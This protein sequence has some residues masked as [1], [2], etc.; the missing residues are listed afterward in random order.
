MKLVHLS[1]WSLILRHQE[2]S[3][4]TLHQQ[5]INHRLGLKTG[6]QALKR[7]ENYQLKRKSIQA[8]GVS[9]HGS[10]VSAFYE[11]VSLASSSTQNLQNLTKI[12]LKN[13][14][15]AVTFPNL[16]FCV[17]TSKWETTL[18]SPTYYLFHLTVNEV[19]TFLAFFSF[20]AAS[21]KYIHFKNLSNIILK[22]SGC[23]F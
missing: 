1:T 8:A 15:M 21:P 13:M 4:N 10:L 14:I 3:R 22:A 17:W 6:I 5:A 19:N 18:S 2:D 7:K 11:A 12:E 23:F 16:R 9:H 20:L